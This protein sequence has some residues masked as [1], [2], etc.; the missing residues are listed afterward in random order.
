MTTATD[1]NKLVVVQLSGGNDYLNTIVPYGN[2]L[3]YDFRGAIHIRPEDVL[4]IDGETGFRPGMEAIKRL[5][6]EGKVAI[7]HGIGYPNPNRSHFRSMDIWHTALAGGHRQRG[8]AR[9]RH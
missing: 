4:P 1:T 9:S 7:I 2:G 8:L 6:D 3:Y 5:W